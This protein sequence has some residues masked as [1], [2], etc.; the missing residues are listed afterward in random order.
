MPFEQADA[1]KELVAIKKL[2]VHQSPI[3][4]LLHLQLD[5]TLRSPAGNQ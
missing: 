5:S 1:V 2:C 3:L 4:Q